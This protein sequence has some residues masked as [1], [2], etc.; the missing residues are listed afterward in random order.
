[1]PLV[2]VISGLAGSGK[3]TLG[4][5]LNKLQNVNVVELD[6]IDDENALELLEKQWAGVDKFNKMKDKM[7]SVSIMNIMDNIKENDI[8]IFVG[9]LDEINKFATHKYFIKPDIVKIYK[10]VNLR[11][12]NDIVNSENAMKKLFNKCETLADI[13][14]TNEI[15]LYKYKI[16]RLFPDGKYGIKHMIDRRTTNANKNDFKIL[17]VDKIYDV[18]KNHINKF[19]SKI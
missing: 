7:N 15:I 3:S 16:R 2:I 13:D 12:L 19:K 10:Q 5:K 11:T 8:Y 1:M 9:L 18:V 17:H 4:E 14:K 6:D